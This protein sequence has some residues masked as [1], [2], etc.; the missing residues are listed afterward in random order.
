MKIEIEKLLRQ[1]KMTALVIIVLISVYVYLAFAANIDTF[2]GYDREYFLTH[3]DYRE[4]LMSKQAEKVDEAWISKTKK[5]Y[6]GLI[7]ENMYSAD[8]I[9]ERLG[10]EKKNGFSVDYTVDD[11]LADPYN[12]EYAFELLPS[13]VFYSH[14]MESFYP[15]VFDIYIPLAEDA[16]GYLHESYE[17]V[18]RIFEEN[19]GISYAECMGYSEAQLNDY[20]DF[21][22]RRYRDFELTVG[23]CLGWDI[24]CTAMQFLPYTLGLALIVVLGSLFSQEKSCGMVPILRTAKN[25]RARLLQQKLMIA[26][27]TATALWLLFQLVMLLAVAL[28]YTLQGAEC[29]AMAFDGKPS[30]YGFTWLEYYLVQCAFSYCGTLVFAL[31]VCCTSSLMS[32][33]LLMPLNLVI[34]LFCGIPINRFCFADTAF[35]LLDKLKAITPPQL[36]AAYPNLQ[37][38]QSYEL[39]P[40]I[41]QL[42]YVMAAAT[43]AETVLMLLLLKKQE[44]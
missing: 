3:E 39:G 29:T 1:R 30:I 13:K 16:V 9:A 42:A 10:W 37:V 24:L 14:D 5:E 2:S 38:Y 22:D 35:S 17:K 44:G 36:M 7:D 25:G 21:V 20:W 4:W 27:C 8:E 32:L 12:I 19:N 33:K 26:L 40:F 15:S 28:S 31:F 23:Y 41:V 6:M 11:V 18:N 43:L 34:T